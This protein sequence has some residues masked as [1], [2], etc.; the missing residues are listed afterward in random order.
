MSPVV[1]T[2]GGNPSVPRGAGCRPAAGTTVINI[3]FPL[4][5]LATLGQRRQAIAFV[6]ALVSTRR[7][8][9][10]RSSMLA[11]STR[12]RTRSPSR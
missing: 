9:I 4:G 12:I 2:A 1:P 5:R 3:F 8:S 7:K 11:F 10:L 6:L